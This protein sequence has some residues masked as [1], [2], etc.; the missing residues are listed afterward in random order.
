MVR[1]SLFNKLT[2]GI[3]IEG[4]SVLDLCSG[5]GIIAAEFL[6]RGAGSVTSVDLDAKNIRQQQEILKTKSLPHWQIVKGDIFRFM[7]QT[8][9]CYD[10]IFADPPYDLP[11]IHQLT[12]LCVNHL[13]DGGVFVLEHRAGI[14]FQLPVSE[15]RNFGNTVMSF[16]TNA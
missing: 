2:H 9:Q 10:I 4:N 1:E 8:D 14:V 12:Q 15:T 7:E 11:G 6:S 13:S 5:S 3:G 16:F